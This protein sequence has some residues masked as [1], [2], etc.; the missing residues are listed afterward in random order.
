MAYTKNHDPWQ[1]DDVF[2]TS[3]MDKFETI[4]TEA[5]A[6]LSSHTHDSLYFTKT[7]MENQFW[8]AGSDGP[9]SGSDADLIYRSGGNLH[10]DAFG[11]I[12]GNT[13]GLI[14]LW[15]G[16]TATIP[17]GWHLCDGNAGTVNLLNKIPIGAGG[18]YAV[19]ATGGSTTFTAA[20][21][22]SI[23]NHTVT[24]AEM[25]T[26]RHPYTDYYGATDPRGYAS[27]SFLVGPAISRSD[28]LY[29]G[30]AGGGQGHGHSAEE[31]SAMTGNAVSCMPPFYGL[32]Y[33]Q[34]I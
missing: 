14:I 17:T 21:A 34:K 29:T 26:H 9:G 12:I 20:G 22:L 16:S 27:G 32:C 13:T 3:I 2:T 25:G 8:Y 1:S 10:G 28:G 7:E 6:H 24:E 15:Y 33:I 4:Y 19:G 30:F 11:T 18:S 23:A 5:S 31:G